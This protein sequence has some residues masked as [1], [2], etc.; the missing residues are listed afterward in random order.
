[1]TTKRDYENILYRAKLRGERIAREKGY[2]DVYAEAFAEGYAE[3]F[4]EG[5]VKAK[6][7]ILKKLQ[8]ENADPSLIKMVA[9]LSLDE[10]LETKQEAN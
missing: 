6:M 5:M 2:T 1:M 8:D 10:I 4:V 7:A 3:G 9:E